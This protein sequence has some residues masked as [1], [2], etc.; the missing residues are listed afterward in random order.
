MY[1]AEELL[2]YRQNLFTLK[3]L[4]KLVSYPSN[5]LLPPTF[6]YREVSAQP[7][8]YSKS[9]LDWQKDKTQKGL[10]KYL[11]QQLTKVIGVNLEAGLE[12]TYNNTTSF[13]G[14]VIIREKA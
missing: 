14:K 8:Q 5:S 13:T 10:G 9:N 3:A 1:K 6:R 4:Q 7:R 11:A 2:S 12:V